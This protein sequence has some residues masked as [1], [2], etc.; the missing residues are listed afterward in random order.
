MWFDGIV[1]IFTMKLRWG[2]IHAF[3]LRITDL[4]PGRIGVLI[5]L[6]LNSQTRV[7]RGMPN[8]VDDHLVADQGPPPPILGNMTEHPML[9][10]VPLTGSRWKV[11]DVDRDPHG[12]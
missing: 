7:G 10:L 12:I 3:H 2:E 8:E 6:G 9:D 11:S 4:Q 1:P 5:Q